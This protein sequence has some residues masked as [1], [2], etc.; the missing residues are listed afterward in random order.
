MMD[1]EP[2]K[3]KEEY[4]LDEFRVSFPTF[5]GDYITKNKI[6][7]IQLGFTL[8][9]MIQPQNSFEVLEV[10]LPEGYE[11]KVQFTT[12][13]QMLND[14]F[15]IRFRS[16]ID[17]PTNDLQKRQ[18]FFVLGY[19]VGGKMQPLKHPTKVEVDPKSGEEKPI[20]REIPPGQFAVSF[21]V[22]Q[23][24]KKMPEG[25]DNV[26]KIKFCDKFP[27]C[28]PQYLEI[29]IPGPKFGEQPFQSFNIYKSVSE[30]PGVRSSDIVQY[31]KSQ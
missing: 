8:K 6:F 23:P 22:K 14:L 25:N 11:L 27:K 19:N 2:L 1:F 26:F 20:L 10:E 4:R 15:P 16:Y 29:T 5:G 30:I 12:D 17:K 28:L 7:D 31:E 24:Q 21:P 18:L 13:I 3:L 9:G